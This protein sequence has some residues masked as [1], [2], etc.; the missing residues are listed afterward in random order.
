MEKIINQYNDAFPQASILIINVQN[1]KIEDFD[2]SISTDIHRINKQK[3]VY[4]I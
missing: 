3:R 2:F 4:G 1:K